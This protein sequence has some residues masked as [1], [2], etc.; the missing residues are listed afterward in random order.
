M[1]GFSLLAV[2]ALSGVVSVA[3]GVRS[4]PDLGGRL[5][6]LE[7]P[8]KRWTLEEVRT[9][10]ASRFRPATG[11]TPNHGFSRS[12]YWFRV[13]LVSAASERVYLESS[14]VVLDRLEVFVESRAAPGGFKRYLVGDT[15]P[16]GGRVIDLTEYVIPVELPAGRPVWIYLRA[17]TEGSLQLPLAL[18]RTEALFT[19]I[20]DRQLFYGPV[21]GLLLVLLIYDLFL[22]A[23]FRES[24]YGYLALSVAGAFL[25]MLYFTGIAQS[26]L[27][28]GNA[29]LADRGYLVAM[30]TT[31]VPMWLFTRT[32]LELR[33]RLPRVDRVFVALAVAGGLVLPLGL[34][35]SYRAT[36]LLIVALVVAG[37]GL[38]TVAGVASLL[39]GYRPARYYVLG[40]GAF[41]IGILVFASEKAGLLPSGMVTNNVHV[42][43]YIATLVLLPLAL[44]E[45]V[46]ILRQERQAAEA[47][48]LQV[49]AEMATRLEEEVARKTA[50]LAERNVELQREIE[51]RER[52]ERAR[53]ELQ[54]SLLQS[55][56]MD[57]I[58]RL[59]G[60]VAHDMNNILT[61]ITLTTEAV[62]AELP[63]GDARTALDDVRAAAKRGGDLAK[64]LLGFARK[65]RYQTERLS[66][67]QVIEEIHRLLRRTIH[68]GVELR[69]ELEPSLAEVAGDPN[70]LGQILVNLAVNAAHAMANKGVFTI[71]TRNEPGLV[72]LE[73]GDTGCGMDE[74][75]RSHLF[76][77]FFT[78]KP[79][80]EGIGLGLS[81]VYGAVEAHGGRIEV[82]SAP[83]Q[84]ATFRIR[85]PALEASPAAPR[86]VSAQPEP[87]LSA[88]ASGTVLV[89]DDETMIRRSTGRLLKALGYQ[90]LEAAHGRE[91]LE[92]FAR[93]RGRIVAVLLDLVMPVMDGPETFRRL[94]E[95]EPALRIVLCSG[96]S[97]EGDARE[98]LR[99][100]AAGFL[101][102]PFQEEQLREAL[103]RALA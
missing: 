67:N 53:V 10:H 40:W 90:V 26:H 100:G 77:P 2:A 5:E 102:K 22:L 21:F 17:E 45:R 46:R 42:L 8:G 1:A 55:Q 48:A 24:A 37:V 51:Q 36:I 75:T 59:A 84:G 80:G 61:V 85:L 11:K 60:G 4:I 93:E 62:Q 65:G 35:G 38:A 44:A 82:E 29:W 9:L 54:Q 52:T 15:V 69:L 97:A 103:A 6:S 28:G 58:G 79:A 47:H 3:P 72:C 63:E 34:L 98:L 25:Y 71:R 66:L 87:V 101:Q 19:A 30:I 99:A 14:Y 16:H 32:F 78:T 33:A 94:R 13:R 68:Q 64:N 95:A 57:A 18:W 91:A 74:A 70:Q 49:K 41:F 83:G 96:Y 43:G 27:C 31:H 50:D 81:M 20:S 92:V 12:A 89:V 39:R 7:D 88:P 86:P 56:K 23:V 73:V 76:E